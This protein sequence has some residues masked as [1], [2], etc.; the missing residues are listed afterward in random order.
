MWYWVL[1]EGHPFVAPMRTFRI[2]ALVYMTS[3]YINCLPRLLILSLRCFP[4][5]PFCPLPPIAIM[6]LKL[7]FPAHRFFLWSQIS[8][9]LLLL[10]RLQYLIIHGQTT[11]PGS[12]GN[13]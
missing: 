8:L 7:S 5:A 9:F 2:N 3:Y 6:Y 1:T 12:G 13:I 10:L 11:G 4:Q